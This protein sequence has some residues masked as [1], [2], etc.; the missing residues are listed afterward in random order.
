VITYFW[1]A[2]V[3]SVVGVAVAALVCAR[4]L[5]ALTAASDQLSKHPLFVTLQTSQTSGD[6]LARAA[7]NMTD[8]A[9]K[10]RAGMQ[11]IGE[12]LGA[13]AAYA[14]FVDAI[15]KSVEELLEVFVPTLRGHA[16]ST[17]QNGCSRRD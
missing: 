2:L 14:T 8:A 17:K 15:A 10:L 12:A 6:E 16:A 3:V 11:A 9:Q 4:K 7:Q 5:P 13:V 1:A